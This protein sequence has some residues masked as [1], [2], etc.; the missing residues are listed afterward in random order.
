MPVARVVREVQAAL[1]VVLAALVELV[2]P[3]VPAV[4]VVLQAGLEEVPEEQADRVVK[5][6]QVAPG[7]LADPTTG[8]ACPA[9]AHPAAQVAP[10]V[11]V[12]QAD[13]A[14]LLRE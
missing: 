12:A 5:A 6:A 1:A 4:R 14:A 10:E 11:L 3:E 7:E 2:G 8:A 9:S 13:P